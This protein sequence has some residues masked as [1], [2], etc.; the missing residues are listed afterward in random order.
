MSWKHIF[1]RS[2]FIPLILTSFCISL[3]FAAC[4]NQT[5]VDNTL[6]Q[7]NNEVLKLLYWQAPTILNPHLSTGNKD[8]EAS[9]ITLEPLA[10]YNP[11]GE[12]VPFLAAEI[13][14]QENGGIAKDGK[15]VTWKLKQGIKWSDGKPFTAADVVFTYDFVKDPANAGDTR[16]IHRPK[17]QWTFLEELGDDG[18]IRGTIFRSLQKLIEIR[19]QT[20][21]FAGLEMELIETQ[22]PQLLA[23]V[24][25]Q[26]GNRV[27]VV[28]NFSEYPQTIGSNRL[29]TAGMGRFF[30]DLYSG[31]TITT[32]E[33]VHLEP[34]QFLWLQ[35]V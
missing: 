8:S 3:F 22:S 12:L 32:A 9:R 5:I 31:Q 29:R 17:M 23:Y 26:A 35:R 25:A 19:K 18:S 10:T 1:S 11:Q 27:I 33:D 21:A 20:P 28:S 7:N 15:S 2:L 30:E 6:T 34:Y 14:S 16:L 24:R 13:P 4:N